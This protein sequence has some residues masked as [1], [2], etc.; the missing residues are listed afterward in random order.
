MV[1]PQV[2]APASLGPALGYSHGIRA[3][4]LLFVAGQIGAVPRG[5]GRHDV[6]S[7][8][9]PAQFE[10]A[11]ENVLAVVR[12]AGGAPEHVVEMTIYVTDMDAYRAA[13][14]ALGEAWRRT[15]GRHYPAITLLEVS[16]L[17]EEGALVEVRALAALGEPA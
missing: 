10:R 11:L 5:D 8:E 3:G 2:V 13:R 17:F 15:M 14:K 1:I 7:P 4:S 6:V 12:E 9:L 16:D